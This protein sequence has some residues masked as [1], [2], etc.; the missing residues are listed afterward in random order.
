MGGLVNSLLGSGDNYKK[1]PGTLPPYI[2]DCV[3]IYMYN[4]K[5]CVGVTTRGKPVPPCIGNS[6]PSRYNKKRYGSNKNTNT[7]TV[8]NTIVIK[9]RDENRIE[10]EKPD[11][12]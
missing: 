8:T 11:K 7:N 5:P 10:I 9:I 4:N 6:D 12:N 3:P 2:V 1:C